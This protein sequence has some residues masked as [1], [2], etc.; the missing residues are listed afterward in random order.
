M[1]DII[2]TEDDI[3]GQLGQK[4]II[5]V[6]SNPVDPDS[7]VEKEVM[8]LI[9]AGYKVSLFV[10]NRE[11]NYLI[12]KDNKIINGHNV[13]RISVGA[14]AAYGAGF[15]S[16]VQYLRF[17]FSL[18]CWLL[19]NRKKYDMCHFCDF[20]TA[21]VGSLACK[22]IN[23]RFVFDIF[24]YL[25]TDA[26]T[27]FQRIIKKFEDGIINR[28]DAVIICTENRK[29]QIENAVPKLLTVIHNSP[30]QAE[31]PFGNNGEENSNI[32]VCYVG[33]LQDY[34]LLK[35]MVHAIAEMEGVELHIGGFGKYVRFMEE[36]AKNSRNIFFYGKLSYEE[37]IR[38]ETTCD[39]LTAIYDPSIGNHRFAAPNKFYEGL[40]LGKPLI[41]VENTGMSDVVRREDIGVLIN[42][43]E[44]DFQRGLRELIDR[45]S[46]W[47]RM[48]QT[49]RNVYNEQFSWETME[50][51]LQDLYK[52]LLPD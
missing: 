16:I 44:R 41:M 21:F 12:R 15:K 3:N 30:P 48:S 1:D 36:A 18:F 33:I 25:S 24:D 6:R 27:L 29:Q 28:A 39:I 45:K 43:S 9:K 52:K 34:R 49:M 40:M 37:T 5:I 42:Y 7:R 20:D 17:Q 11:D 46:E 13:L 51:R 35:E 32:K 19:A 4:R 26:R 14:R 10:W 31:Y 8:A 23:K 22:L 47:A 50:T 38:L 2:R